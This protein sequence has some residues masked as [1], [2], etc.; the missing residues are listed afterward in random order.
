MMYMLHS[1]SLPLQACNISVVEVET[2]LVALVEVVAFFVVVMIHTL[3][4]SF[5]DSLSLTR[6]HCGLI[7]KCQHNKNSLMLSRRAKGILDATPRKTKKSLTVSSEVL[8]NTSIC[9]MTMMILTMRIVA[10][11]FGF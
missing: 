3:F 10:L 6:G 2:V 7:W 11:S 4:V 1:L 8:L 9:N 5:A